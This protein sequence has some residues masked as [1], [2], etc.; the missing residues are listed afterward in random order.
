MVLWIRRVNEWLNGWIDECRVCIHVINCN[1]LV[2]RQVM[3]KL[4]AI[5][6]I[7]EQNLAVVNLKD[8]VRVGYDIYSSCLADSYNANSTPTRS[9]RLLNYGQK[10]R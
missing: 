5:A 8:L 6:Y 2:C 4:L 7:I 3:N 1:L 9:N 10:N